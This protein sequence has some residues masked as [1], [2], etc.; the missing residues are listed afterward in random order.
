M[1][2]QV[3]PHQKPKHSARVGHLHS[4]GFVLVAVLLIIALAVVLVVTTSSVSQTERKAV[5][6]SANQEAARQNALFALNLAVS[7]LQVA[8]GPDQRVTATADILNTNNA[9]PSP[10]AQPYWTGVWKSYNP[11]YSPSPWFRPEPLDIDTTGGVGTTNTTLRPWST[12]VGPTWLVSGA[13]NNATI[14]PLSSTTNWMSNSVVMASNWGTGTNGSLTGATWTNSTTVTVPLVTLS[15]GATNTGK[16]GYWVSDEGVKAK[17]SLTDTNM[18]AAA[19]SSVNNWIPSLLHY[20]APPAM[21]VSSVMTSLGISTTLTTDFRSNT[22]LTKMTSLGGLSLIT[23]SV[24]IFSNNTLAA[25][26]TPYSYG[27]LSDT[28]MGGLKQDLTSAFESVAPAASGTNFITLQARSGIGTGSDASSLFRVSNQGIPAV[29]TPIIPF[30]GTAV[31][32]GIRWQGLYYFYNLYKSSMPKSPIIGSVA[33]T[34][35]SGIGAP[36]T[37]S[38]NTIGWR[39]SKWN[40]TNTGGS[41][42]INPMGPNLIANRID[43]SITAFSSVVGTNTVYRFRVQ[44]YPMVVM[45]NPYPV[46]L[47]I[48][49]AAT[50]MVVTKNCL[51]TQVTLKCGTNVITN[52]TWRT[53][54]PSSTNSD[55]S[56]NYTTNASNTATVNNLFPYTNSTNP[57]S[58]DY[59]LFQG[60]F[61]PMYQSCSNTGILAP[62]EIRVFAATVNSPQASIANA[63]GFSGIISDASANLDACQYYDAPWQ[64]TTNPNDSVTLT[65]SSPT[66]SV[67]SYNMYRWYPNLVN[68]WPAS[69]SGSGYGFIL[70]GVLVPSS[71]G[72]ATFSWTPVTIGQM[73]LNNL[74]YRILGMFERLKG[75]YSDGDT[76]FINSSFKLPIFMGNSQSYNRGR[77]GSTASYGGGA[78]QTTEVYGRAGNQITIFSQLANSISG[79]NLTSCWGAASTGS[80]TVNPNTVNTSSTA[81]N[82]SKLVLNDIPI[83]PMTSLGQFMHYEDFYFNQ[84]YMTYTIPSMSVGG[85]FACPN[86]SISANNLTNSGSGSTGNTP[87]ADN[88][89]M[90]NEALFDTYYFSTVP[91]ASGFN[92]GS[93]GFGAFSNSTI[94]A[95]AIAANQPLPN[96]RLIYY[97]KNGSN[98]VVADLQDES[99]A[100]ANLL[101]DGAFNVNSTSIAA[102]KALLTSLSGHTFHTYNYLTGA[103]ED[104][105][106]LNPIPRFWS[107]SRSA[108]NDP[109]DGMR[110]LTDAQVTA[111]A[112]EIVKQV[113]QRGPFLSL[114]DFLNRRLSTT[115]SQ[116]SAMGAIQAAIENTQTNSP[117]STYDVN[118]NIHSVANFGQAVS[119]APINTIVTNTATGIP[120]YLMQQDIVQA[121]APVLAARSDTFMIRVYGESDKPSTNNAVTTTYSQAWGEAVVQ[122]LPDYFDQTDPQLASTTLTGYALG[123]ATPPYSSAGPVLNSAN[124]TF[125]RR[126]KIVSFRWLNQNEL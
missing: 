49:G 48:G 23:N 64:G 19:I 53:I 31:V 99:K 5:S 98:P 41:Y 50:N 110:S 94:T 18:S 69:A 108:A 34:S 39:N 7:Q 43:T 78:G 123:D 28:R 125:G 40:E 73:A 13:T 14:S 74:S 120:G 82:N 80:N 100:A 4:G 38:A 122:R 57:A 17:V 89:Y 20:F 102:W 91:P 109:W 90:A 55:G 107:V 105:N 32:D 85:S 60:A 63:C 126:F 10:V 42:L 124:Q 119:V 35:P 93:G 1:T 29:T 15:N 114:G 95:A 33:G 83:A 84:G 112:T 61:Y 79:T 116:L 115:T 68:S 97:R 52:A 111:L 65:L 47:L 118:W 104:R 75:V 27:V 113:R 16:Y 8:A 2:E 77:S 67:S 30:G 6:N 92:W 62:G 121:F 86:V 72:N 117:A 37:S 106:L 87:I 58:P 66:P 44:Y 12:N 26:L 11:A 76:N 88:S 3:N 56:V 103:A 71:S 24:P 59:S 51:G 9:T 81:A 46:N 101:L 22:N 96:S 25:D 36:S 54:T 70:P 21:N 45:H